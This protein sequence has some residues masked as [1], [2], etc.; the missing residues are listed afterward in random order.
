[1]EKEG[2]FEQSFKGLKRVLLGFS[3]STPNL[4]P[5]WVWLTP[6]VDGGPSLCRWWSFYLYDT[7]PLKLGDSVTIHTIQTGSPSCSQHC[8][9]STSSQQLGI[10]SSFR[11]S[12]PR[13]ATNTLPKY[14]L[15]VFLSPPV[16]EGWVV[17]LEKL[18]NM[19]SGRDRPQ[20]FGRLL[21]QSFLPLSLDLPTG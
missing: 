3:W 9:H 2:H 16:R 10:H 19:A 5:L 17:I 14:L 11:T 15:L 20:P 7:L 13:H 1:S 12:K 18:I 6:F 4:T 21:W 8:P